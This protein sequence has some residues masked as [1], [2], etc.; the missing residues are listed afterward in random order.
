MATGELFAF[1]TQAAALSHPRLMRSN[2][3]ADVG[4]LRR[5]HIRLSIPSGGSQKRGRRMGLCREAWEG[6]FLS[7]LFCLSNVTNDCSC[8]FRGGKE[9]CSLFLCVCWSRQSTAIVHLNGVNIWWKLSH[10]VSNAAKLHRAM[11][12][13]RDEWVWVSQGQ[14]E[15]R[16]WIYGAEI[17]VPSTNI[18]R[19]RV[20][21]AIYILVYCW[22][23]VVDHSKIYDDANLYCAKFFLFFFSWSCLI[24]TQSRANTFG[25]SLF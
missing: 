17:P 6:V 8:A 24:L 10:A 3:V 22:F 23:L 19:F 7:F 18:N 4:G 25:N 11:F 13:P 2:N 21:L 12:Q 14:R 5:G 9:H 16:T 1:S 15:A 20:R